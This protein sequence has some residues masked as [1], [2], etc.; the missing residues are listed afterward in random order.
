M[1]V[2]NPPAWIQQGTYPARTDRLVM[3]S[4]V[5]SSGRVSLS[6]LVVTQSLTPGMRVTVSAG[7]AWILGTSVVYQGA[8]NFVNDAPIEIN[9]AAS[10]TLY[11]RRDVVIARIQDSSVS[12]AV[13]SATIEVVTGTPASSPVTPA[14]PANSLVLAVI[15]VPA[16][17][18]SITTA[19]IDT[20][21]VLLATM[22]SQMKNDTIVC[23]STTRPTGADR[24][25]GARILETDTL[26]EWMWI[27]N[28]WS[29]RGGGPAPR[30][31]IETSTNL[32]WGNT[33]GFVYNMSPVAGQFDTTYYSF[34][35]GSSLTAGDRIKVT[36]SGTYTV[37]IGFWSDKVGAYYSQ[38]EPVF[39]PALTVFTPAADGVSSTSGWARIK[40]VNT[41]Y[42]SAGQE[43]SV[44]VYMNSAGTNLAA[45]WLQLS[46]IP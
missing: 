46:M 13:D 16:N 34:V 28:S 5:S 43:V 40:N 21:M 29:Y 24:F 36:Q 14:T 4:L 44:K 1:T 41:A 37:E 38:V 6:D 20:S 33:T 23:T 2:V 42:L 8:Y 15:T 3:S 30:A 9:I 45:C 18:T 35:N 11:A 31:R 10:S 26:R 12:G 25:V 22:F 19:N 27:G 39:G 7:R 17:A 32:A